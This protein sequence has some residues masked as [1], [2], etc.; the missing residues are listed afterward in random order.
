LKSFN[1]ISID[2]EV[3]ETY[4]TLYRELK[5]EGVSLPDADLLIA[6]TAISHNR[7]LKTR[8]EHFERLRKLGL[9]LG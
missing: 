3:I 5:R 9:K 6:A 8:D 7:I 1:L 4:C 2:N